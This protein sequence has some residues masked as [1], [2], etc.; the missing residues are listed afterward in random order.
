MDTSAAVAQ[1]HYQAGRFS[2]AATELEH[3]DEPWNKNCHQLLPIKNVDKDKEKQVTIV[4]DEN[5][6]IMA[7]VHQITIPTEQKKP[8]KGTRIEVIALPPLARCADIAMCRFRSAIA[9]SYGGDNRFA[10]VGNENDKQKAPPADKENDG[11]TSVLFN[12]WKRAMDTN[13]EYRQALKGA[14]ISLI[15][16]CNMEMQAAQSIQSANQ[17]SI[18]TTMKSTTMAILMAG[19][20]ASHLYL[21]HTT[22]NISKDSHAWSVL[23]DAAILAADLMQKRKLFMNHYLNDMDD[24]D[25]AKYNENAK[26]TKLEDCLCI[27]NVTLCSNND[28]NSSTFIGRS[29]NEYQVDDDERGNVAMHS[30]RSALKV[31]ALASEKLIL[32][33]LSNVSGNVVNEQPKRQKIEKEDDSST[34]LD[35]WNTIYIHTNPLLH[36]CDRLVDALSFHTAAMKYPQSRE[37]CI[38]MREV[39]FDEA[40]TYENQA[41]ALLYDWSDQNSD[42]N[43]NEGCVGYVW[44]VRKSIHGLEI[45][46][47]PLTSENEDKKMTTLQSIEVLAKS[48]SQFGCNLLGCIYAQR[49]DFSLAMEKFQQALDQGGSNDLQSDEEV[50]AGMAQHRTLV[51]LAFC[52]LS[53]GEVDTPLELLLHLWSTVSESQQSNNSSDI[54]PMAMLLSLTSSGMEIHNSS[55]ALS[56]KNQLLW[57][58][59][60]ASSLAQDWSTC[61]NTTEEMALITDSDTQYHAI[62]HAFALLQCRRSAAAQDTIRLLL[63]KLTTSQNKRL[64]LQVVAELFHADTMLVNEDNSINHSFDESDKPFVC[65]QRAINTLDA[66]LGKDSSETTQSITTLTELQVTTYNNHGIALLMKGD[67]V[68]ALHCFREATKYVSITAPTTTTTLPWQLLPTYFNLSLLLLRDGHIEESAKSWLYAR[69]YFTTWQSAMRGNNDALQELK[70]LRVMAINRHGLLM[71]KRSIAHYAIQENIMEWVP[72]VSEGGDVKEDSTR[73]GGVDASQ[74]T[75]LDVVLLKHALALAEKRSSSSFRKNHIIGY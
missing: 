32:P 56:T 41:G 70:N 15:H 46:S 31:A 59:F 65:T 66:M 45:A 12:L 39:C 69:D 29:I 22:N 62:V 67:S 13:S 23:V 40:I 28:K 33:K 18:Q 63:Q 26:L 47:S 3:C 6:I 57:K 61:L 38:D 5:E 50:S 36:S 37:I 2:Q 52:F 51:N 60:N 17:T 25:D 30:F 14:A 1:C 19:V 9:S 75:A 8:R 49:N 64:L 72:P 42:T 34:K 10:V 43:D 20:S 44:K 68:G 24:D 73:I 27:L 74:I 7:D 55:N 58:L 11:D 48:N 21:H 54:Q 53:M 4:Q 71:A 35:A 16:T